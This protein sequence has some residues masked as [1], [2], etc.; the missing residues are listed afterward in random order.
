[1][2]YK[3]G[4][5]RTVTHL[6][7]LSIHIKFQNYV[8]LIHLSISHEVPV[9]V[10]VLDQREP[11]HH[12]AHHPSVCVHGA[13]PHFPLQHSE[14]AAHQTASRTP[15]RVLTPFQYTPAGLFL[16]RRSPSD[17]KYRIRYTFRVKKNTFTNHTAICENWKDLPMNYSL[18]ISCIGSENQTLR[19]LLPP[20]VSDGGGTNSLRYIELLLCT[21]WPI[22]REESIAVIRREN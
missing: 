2:G 14:G 12:S 13:E 9:F 6:K 19:S 5:S 1:M 22:A 11:L 17:S 20:A 8:L 3:S 21:T 18:A 7:F 15:R 4:P 16:Y 10:Q